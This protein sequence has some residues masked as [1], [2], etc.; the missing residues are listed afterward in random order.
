MQNKGHWNGVPILDANRFTVC[1]KGGKGAKECKRTYGDPGWSRWDPQA[2]GS[3]PT[4]SYMTSRRGV[5]QRE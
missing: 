2:P 4:E 1:N 5:G 3:G